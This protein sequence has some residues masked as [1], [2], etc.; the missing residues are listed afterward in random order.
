MLENSVLL[1]GSEEAQ[2]YAEWGTELDASCLAKRPRWQCADAMA[3]GLEDVDTP[4]FIAAQT[5]DLKVRG[6]KAN[7]A[8]AP[9]ST[10]EAGY[11]MA[12][13]PNDFD[14]RVR[15]MV[16]RLDERNVGHAVFVTNTDDHMSLSSDVKIAR[17]IGGLPLAR[18]LYGWLVAR[19]GDE[20]ICISKART[21]SQAWFHVLRNRKGDYKDEG[22]DPV[23]TC[24]GAKF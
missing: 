16:K 8:R 11:G 24:V 10:L 3:V 19:P 17:R 2:S 15:A 4:L 7:F 6:F 12:Y 23:H 22:A 1:P 5:A 21:G 20:T 14:K 13:L 9:G 18:V